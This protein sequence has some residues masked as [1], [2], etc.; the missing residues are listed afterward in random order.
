MI[1]SKVTKEQLEKWRELHNIWKDKLTVNRISGKEL[2]EYFWKK[3]NPAE[4]NI[5]SF[6]TVVYLNSE[7]YNKKADMSEIHTYTLENN[8]YVGIDTATGFFQVECEDIDKAAPVWDDIFIKRGL[9]ADDIENY[10]LTGQYISL[11]GGVVK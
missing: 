6:R 7:A 8:V 5:E 3:Y 4:N 2:D 10:V 11:C 1:T 9:S